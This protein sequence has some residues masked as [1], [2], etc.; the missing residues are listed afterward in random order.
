[1]DTKSK[2]FS[3][4]IIVRITVF[5]VF[6]ILMT[7]ALIGGM[8]I[9]SSGAGDVGIDPDD[10]FNS[11]GSYLDSGQLQRNLYWEADSVLELFTEYKSEKNIR[12]GKTVNNAEV[13]GMTEEMYETGFVYCNGKEF[14]ADYDYDGYEEFA[15]FEGDVKSR[16]IA[17][18]SKQ[19]E[20]I[21]Q[22]IIE[23]DLAY[24]KDRV[25]HFNSS[26]GF[27][28]SITDGTSS[29]T[30]IKDGKTGSADFKKYP[31]YFIYENGE[32]E[33]K[34]E[35][36]GQGY[37]YYNY[38]DND[39]WL[40]ENSEMYGSDTVICIAYTDEYVDRVI[41]EYDRALDAIHEW[42][43]MI[44]SS[45]IGALAALLWLM[46]TTGGKRPDGTHRLY[47]ID[48]LWTEIQLLALAGTVCGGAAA[49]FEALQ[50]AYTYYWSNTYD[51][52]AY[53]YGA[54]G[55]AASGAIFSFGGI[56][57]ICGFAL[58]AAVA[59]WYLLSLVR[60][61]KAHVFI[62]TSL[63]YKFCRFVK[64]VAWTPIRGVVHNLINGGSLMRKTA[65]IALLVC[66]LSATVFLAP[67]VFIF[68]L[69][70]APRWLSRFEEIQT[71]VDEVRSGNLT[72]KIPIDPEKPT[73]ELSRLAKGINEISEASN[74]AVQN[75]LKNQRMKTELISNVSH[76]LKTPLTSM[77]SYIDLLKK[78]GLDSPNAPEYLDILY[79]K[80]ERLR[81]L[82]ED[83]FEAAKASSGAMP[84]NLE[85]VDLLSLVNQSMGEMS[86][87]IEASS[88][89]FILNAEKDRY[90][91]RA[92]GQLLYRVV[93][94]LIVNV[95]KYAQE[96]SR[97]Y[98]DIKEP[99]AGRGAK[100]GS[101]AGVQDAAS[102][103]GAGT[104]RSEIVVLEIKNMSKQQLNINADELMER[105]KRGDDSRTTE[106]SGLGLAIAKDLVKL[107][108]GWFEIAIDGDLFK[109]RVVLNKADAPVQM[110][111]DA[112]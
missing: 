34:P 72:Y 79:Q 66:L 105:F 18:N 77:V 38:Y 57:F 22:A 26:D 55:Y 36:T 111:D 89:D 52:G 47:A 71:G 10:I 11:D 87:R 35:Y 86:A 24:F 92:D 83:L 70:F 90:Y 4:N 49:G 53:I 12:A 48:K 107:M 110:A 58:L 61:L 84:V 63:T 75:E 91:V 112:E 32:L 96:G 3:Q 97:V 16:F 59:L 15:D 43:P 65:I 99:L 108:D 14:T 27:V 73:D 94:N 95:L 98:I 9:F 51:A 2:K 64:N 102:A 106:G 20:G 13:G 6:V 101:A 37:N 29:M 1:M 56:T 80:T 54:Q 45:L 100:Y 41:T 46:V 17:A 25:K 76:D 103:Q 74:I 93:E 68:I 85:T 67:V 30:N 81:K 31:V 69:V 28:Y 5:I 8:M 60:L 19:I 78:E 42:L 82:T 62:K 40:I 39:E 88:L 23:R 50:Y 109:A 7:Q 44:I 33:R 21:R 104:G